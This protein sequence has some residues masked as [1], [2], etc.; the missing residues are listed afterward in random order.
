MTP[1]IPTVHLGVVLF[2]FFMNVWGFIIP[3]L[4]VWLVVAFFVRT[5]MSGLHRLTNP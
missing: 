3:S 4:C 2:W 5:M 1:D